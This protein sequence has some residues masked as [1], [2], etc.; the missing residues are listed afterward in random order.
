MVATK[1]KVYFAFLF[2]YNLDM[3]KSYYLKLILVNLITLSRLISAI[4]LPILYF[5]NGVTSLCILIP[6]LFVTDLIDGK[7]S[8]YFKVETFLGSIL[9]AVSDK[10]FAFVLETSI[11]IMYLFIGMPLYSK[12]LS[13]GFLTKLIE[14]E[15]PINYVLIGI[16]I[17]MEILTLTDYKKKSAKQTSY[18]KI[19]FK[20]L[21]S[22]KEIIKLLLDR[23][24]YIKN[25]NTKLKELLYRD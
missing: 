23:E 10:V 15:K 8:R 12:Y 17:G 25:K 22:T 18:E 21:K 1:A 3:K 7:L 11:V 13:S 14:I 16:M 19:K 9:D 5:K 6:F 24:F 20:E 4:L 2:C